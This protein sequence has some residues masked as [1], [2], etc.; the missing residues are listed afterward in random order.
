MF[1]AI[2]LPLRNL[3]PKPLQKKDDQGRDSFAARTCLRPLGF[4]KA[5]ARM[6]AVPAPDGAPGMKI[7]V[8]TAKSDGGS[9]R[10]WRCHMAI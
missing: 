10:C 7:R 1:Y 4:G 8:Y 2:A 5:G 6:G 9:L 3:N